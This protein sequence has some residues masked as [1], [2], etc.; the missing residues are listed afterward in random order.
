MITHEGQLTRSAY[1][2]EDFE[3]RY[4]VKMPFGVFLHNFRMEEYPPRLALLDR[5][6]GEWHPQARK[7]WIDVADA[8]KGQ[9]GPWQVSIL[10]FLPAARK[11]NTEW[12]VS[13]TA[14]SS[15]AVLVRLN[16]AES[17]QLPAA[18][19]WLGFPAPDTDESWAILDQG[20]VLK[21][22]PPD[23]KK[24]QSE[25]EIV[26][27]AGKSRKALLEVN[28]PVYYAGWYIYQSSYDSTSGKF[29]RVSILEVSSDPWL[30]V[31]YL[32]V[33]LTLLGVLR[34]FWM[35]AP[36]SRREVE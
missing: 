7:R 35:G 12:V 20:A 28:K 5:T 34:L 23:P 2:A 13:E 14:G 27:D 29:S 15:P 26:D 4:P 16:S 30:P 8:A 25:I 21:L 3:N 10:R 18:D 19:Y 31:V 32:G 6:T 1:W 24:F 9:L 11:V 22:I 33:F 36:A 17:P